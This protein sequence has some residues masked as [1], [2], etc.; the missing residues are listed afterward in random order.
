MMQLC[1]YAIMI[2]KQ[3]FV[4]CTRKSPHFDVAVN[5]ELTKF[6]RLQPAETTNQCLEMVK[7]HL[8]NVNLEHIGQMVNVQEDITAH[9]MIVSRENPQRI[10]K[11]LVLVLVWMLEWTL[12]LP[13]E[14]EWKQRHSSPQLRM[15]PLFQSVLPL[16][17]ISSITLA[18]SLLFQLLPIFLA[19]WSEDDNLV[20]T[21]VRICF[22]SFLPIVSH[23]QA[24][25]EKVSFQHFKT[26]TELQGI[27]RKEK[28]ENYPLFRFK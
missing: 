24:V 22:E 13:L 1:K 17:F 12:F 16:Y 14:Q 15:Q 11:L 28:K 23:K 19:N 3:I 8:E 9:L 25:R 18:T 21:A 26:F 10:L 2:A 4:S 27:T 6:L 5:I 20:N 7:I